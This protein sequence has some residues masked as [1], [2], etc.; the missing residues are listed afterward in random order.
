MGE[1][2]RRTYL[3]GETV[4]QTKYFYALRPL[5]ACLFLLEHC[6][7]VPMR[8][9]ALVDA[10]SVPA[11]V[12]EAM[13]DLLRNKRLASE[14]AEAQRLPVLDAWIDGTLETLRTRLPAAVSQLDMAQLDRFFRRAIGG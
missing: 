13:R 12:Q 2:Q 6:G 14:A 3:T 9:F 1:G 8:F 10:T 5:L 7:P 4:R 11:D